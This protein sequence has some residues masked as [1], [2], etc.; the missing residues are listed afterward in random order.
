[1]SVRTITRTMNKAKGIM[2]NKRRRNILKIQGGGENNRWL[3]EY[4]LNWV[5]EKPT[6]TPSLH[7]V[8]RMKYREERKRGGKRERERVRKR[9]R[10]G[11]EL[12]KR[13][14]LWSN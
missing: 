7:H 2:Y 9:V 14:R 13:S 3:I 12:K 11:R 1:M 5:R 8:T 6:E 4:R 10:K